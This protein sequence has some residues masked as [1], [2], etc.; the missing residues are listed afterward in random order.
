MTSNPIS[1]VGLVAKPRVDAAARVLVELTAWLDARGLQA[2]LRDRHRAARR[3]HR[4]AR[5]RLE[6]RP[7]ARLRPDRPARRRRHA[8]RHGA[9]GG[10]RR[11]DVPIAGVN[12]G[13]LGFLTEITLDDLYPSLEAVLDGTAPIEERMMLHAQDDARRQRLHRRAR[14]E[15]RRHHQGG[16]VADHRAAGLHRR[17]PGDAGPRRWAD[18][19]HARP[20]PPPTTSPRAGRSCSRWSTRC[21]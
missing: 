6:G 8:D 20:D 19:R 17:R 3:D 2:D 10:A 5:D 16:A 11:R 14:A 7:A 1:R 9:A 13:S 18:R 12:F 4:R 15:R 21:C